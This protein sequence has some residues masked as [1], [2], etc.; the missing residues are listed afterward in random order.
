MM[1]G[2]GIHFTVKVHF[3]REGRRIEN[4][5]AIIATNQV[6]LHFARD[7]RREAPFQVFTD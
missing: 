3:K 4:C 1:E 6:A 5:P 2:G 7:V